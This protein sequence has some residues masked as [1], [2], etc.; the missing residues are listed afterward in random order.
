MCRGNIGFYEQSGAR[1]WPN[2]GFIAVNDSEAR[3][4]NKT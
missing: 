1:R 3:A 4:N 2:I